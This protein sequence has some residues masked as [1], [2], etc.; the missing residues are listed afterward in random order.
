M[1]TNQDARIQLLERRRLQI[2]SLEE[3][4]S[5]LAKNATFS[6]GEDTTKEWLQRCE[7]SLVELRKCESEIR[8]WLGIG[9]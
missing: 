4:I 8:G 5:F 2:E 1:T 3:Q 7:T 6:N 9:E